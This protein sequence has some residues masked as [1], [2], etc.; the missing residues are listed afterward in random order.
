MHIRPAQSHEA[1]IVAD[2][3]AA[4]AAH[5]RAKGEIIWDPPEISEAAI[6][7]HVRAG[8]YHLAFDDEG[9][10]G[11]FRFQLD[12]N[13][14]WPD[15]PAGSSGFVHKLAVYPGK[16]G[17]D[18]AQTLLA[19]ACDL[20]RQHGRPYLR[21]DCMSGKPRLRAVYERFGFRLHSQKE[22]DGLLF[23]RFELALGPPLVR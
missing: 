22:L 10:V 14:F 17:A 13:F 3:L 9:P 16:Q 21:L 11:A 12:D 8:M 18:I 2:I 15:V 5:I 23:D 1:G 6:G 7:G 19:H 4:A 20:A